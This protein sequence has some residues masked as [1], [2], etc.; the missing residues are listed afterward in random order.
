MQAFSMGLGEWEETV[1]CP[2]PTDSED[3]GVSRVEG[4]SLLW[5]CL[6]SLVPP[7]VGDWVVA[8]IGGG[9]RHV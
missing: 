1:D 5:V 6:V 3:L 9:E 8:R 4:P 7:S 2:A